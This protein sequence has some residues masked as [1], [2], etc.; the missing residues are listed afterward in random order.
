MSARIY[1]LFIC[2]MLAVSTSPIIARYLYHIDPI[3][4]SFWRMFIG[5]MILVIYGFFSRIESISND[6]K[7]KTY[8]AGLLL[9]LHFLYLSFCRQLQ[10]VHLNVQLDSLKIQVVV[11]KV[12]VLLVMLSVAKYLH[13]NSLMNLEC[14]LVLI[15]L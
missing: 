7:Y 11:V 8:I 9:G 13:R 4:I 15:S 5:G 2:S 10:M 3:S 6:N 14:N 1:I 12:V